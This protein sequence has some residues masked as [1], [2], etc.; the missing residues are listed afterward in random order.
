M[1]ACAHCGHG[2]D[3]GAR[4][5]EACGEPLGAMVAHEAAPPVAPEKEPRE[6]ARIVASREALIG[7]IFLPGLAQ[8]ATQ[9]Q[10][11]GAMLLGAGLV[12]GIL[13]CGPGWFL[14]GALSAFLASAANNEPPPELPGE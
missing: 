5:C 10:T 3:A 9:N 2:N 4:T 6:P 1:I 7:S 8:F 13:T 12:A 11:V 14:V